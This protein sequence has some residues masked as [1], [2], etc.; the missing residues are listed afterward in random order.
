MGRAA[1]HWC[2]AI[3]RMRLKIP[4]IKRGGMRPEVVIDME[5]GA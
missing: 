5:L 4:M 1:V 2:P 3:L